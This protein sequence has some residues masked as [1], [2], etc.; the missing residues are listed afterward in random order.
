MQDW[1]TAFKKAFIVWAILVAIPLSI[2]IG[3]ASIFSIE[4]G[5]I[6][7]FVLAILGGALL[8]FK[9]DI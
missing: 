8:M 7:G 9:E 3:I 1:I 2:G 5:F 6:V 4:H